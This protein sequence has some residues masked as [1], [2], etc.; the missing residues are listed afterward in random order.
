MPFGNVGQRRAL[1]TIEIMFRMRL[2][3]HIYVSS[4]T[5]NTNHHHT[6]WFHGHYAFYFKWKFFTPN[7]SSNRAERFRAGVLPR[8]SG[9]SFCCCFQQQ[10]ISEMIHLKKLL[11]ELFITRY[12]TDTEQYRIFA[13]VIVH[14]D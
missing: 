8:F 9:C 3:I 1:Y 7:I 4:N 2:F 14:L 10:N 12:L 11:L 6:S 5:S 13:S